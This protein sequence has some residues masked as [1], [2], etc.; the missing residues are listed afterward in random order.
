MKDA[1]IITAVL[2]LAIILAAQTE[3]GMFWLRLMMSGDG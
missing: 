2:A 1:I 3:E